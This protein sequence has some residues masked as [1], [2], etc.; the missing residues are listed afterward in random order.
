MYHKVSAGALI[1]G[2]RG[3]VLVY[4]TNSEEGLRRE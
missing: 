2:R 4:F 3:Q 1:K